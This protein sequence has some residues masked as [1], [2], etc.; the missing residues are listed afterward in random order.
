MMC[1]A[2]E[3]PNDQPQHCEVRKDEVRKDDCRRSVFRTSAVLAAITRQLRRLTDPERRQALPL[4]ESAAAANPPVHATPCGVATAWPPQPPTATELLP[5]CACAMDI[6]PGPVV[7]EYALPPEF[8]PARAVEPG[9]RLCARAWPPP[10][11]TATAVPLDDASVALAELPAPARAPQPL[12]PEMCCTDC[13]F[14]ALQSVAACAS[15]PPSV[16]PASNPAPPHTTAKTRTAKVLIRN[17]FGLQ[18]K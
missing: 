15:P 8:A 1:A 10:S 13:P 16:N 9:C 17:L 2:N 11:A 4:P 14:A 3:A 5:R 12:V 18:A 6:A 7:T